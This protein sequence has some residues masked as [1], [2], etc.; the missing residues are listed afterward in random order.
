MAKHSAIY[1]SC[2]ELEAVQTLVSTVECALKHVSDWLD[3]SGRE[4]SG[5]TAPGTEEEEVEE[6]GS[7]DSGISGGGSEE[8]EDCR[9]GGRCSE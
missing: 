1:P 3:Q 2:Q 7:G 8:A 5:Q 4:V 9:D 6:D